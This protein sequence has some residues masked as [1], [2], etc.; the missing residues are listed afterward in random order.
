MAVPCA[1]VVQCVTSNLQLFTDAIIVYCSVTL[2]ADI[3]INYSTPVF[4]I[5]RSDYLM[6]A[7]PQT[8][9][10]GVKEMFAFFVD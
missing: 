9:F 3:V 2:F 1:F 10:C 5:S 8:R 4:A 6:I 7:L